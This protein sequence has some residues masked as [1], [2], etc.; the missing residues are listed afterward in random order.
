ML[1]TQRPENIQQSAQCIQ[2]KACIIWSTLQSGHHRF[3]AG[4]EVHAIGEMAQSIT[5]APASTAFR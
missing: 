2:V 1:F 4:W 3:A 5:S